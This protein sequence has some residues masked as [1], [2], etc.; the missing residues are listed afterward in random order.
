MSFNFPYISST[1]V[2]Y[3]VYSDANS[4]KTSFKID[5]GPHRIIHHYGSN[6]KNIMQESE[7]YVMLLSKC[8]LPRLLNNSI[9][10]G[11]AFIKGLFGTNDDADTIIDTLESAFGIDRMDFIFEMMPFQSRLNHVDKLK[12]ETIFFKM[13]NTTDSKLRI[14]ISA[15]NPFETTK[16]RGWGV[17]YE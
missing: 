3:S 13:K 14:V 6:D 1:I 4:L 8:E 11:E 10:G 5:F 12:Y 17:Y 9:S 15:T 2:E 7:H 16:G